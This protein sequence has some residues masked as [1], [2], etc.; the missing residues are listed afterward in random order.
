ME[1]KTAL[2]RMF[3]NDK[4]RCFI[5]LKDHKLN[6]LITPRIYLLKPEK[7][8]RITKI[9]L[10]KINLYLRNITEVN[11]WKNTSGAISWFKNI[12]MKHN[13]LFNL[14]LKIF[15][16]QL[17]R[18]SNEYKLLKMVRKW[19]INRKKCYYLTKETREWRKGGTYSM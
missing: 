7:L 2:S 9:L 18:N 8:G 11:Q 3:I 5:T 10:D 12:K 16:L 13:C 14:I 4:N 6:F 15:T 17:L 1:N 19:Y